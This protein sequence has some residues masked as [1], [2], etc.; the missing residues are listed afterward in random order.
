[1]HTNPHL[2][3][4]AMTT[5]K[6]RKFVHGQKVR[7]VGTG[8]LTGKIGEVCSYTSG[9]TGYRIGFDLNNDGRLM[10]YTCKEENLEAA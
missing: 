5:T 8:T 2:G 10:G 1:M 9:K 4:H 7:Y 6:T 3:K